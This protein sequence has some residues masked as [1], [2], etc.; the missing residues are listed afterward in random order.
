MKMKKA[1]SLLAA[2][3][4][5][6]VVSG[7]TA[8]ADPISGNN[9]GSGDNDTEWNEDWNTAS[10]KCGDTMEWTLDTSDGL[11]TISGS[12]NMW[13]RSSHGNELW[14]SSG[15][16]STAFSENIRSIGCGS[17]SGC[18]ELTSVTLPRSIK[19]IGESAFEGCTS[20]TD[21]Q[22]FNTVEVIGDNCFSGCDSLTDVYFKGSRQ[23]WLFLTEGVN[24][25]ISS[26]VSMHYTSSISITSQP[27]NVKVVPGAVVDFS[28]KATGNGTLKYQWYFRK[29]GTSKWSLWKKHTTETVSAASNDTWDG[30]QV[31]CRIED[32]EN[33][34]SS[35]V[36]IITLVDGV[37]IITQPSNVTVYSGEEASF[38]V[39]AQGNALNYQWYYRKSGASTWSVWKSHTTSTTTARAN[40]T[41]DGMQVYCRVSNSEGA[42]SDSKPATI[43][44]GTMPRILTHPSDVTVD[45]GK[46]VSFTVKAEGSGLKYQWYFKKSGASSWNIWKSHTTATTTARANDTWNGMQVYCKVSDS[47]GAFSDSQ[48]AT[49]RL[50][51][52]PVI[53]TQPADVTVDSGKE[54]SFTVKAEG[55]NLQY[56]WYFKKSGASG[57]SVWKSHTS[58]TTT[59][60]ANDTWDG[61]QVYCVVTD[62]IG[63]TV[64]S[65]SA[66]VK[67]NQ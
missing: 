56:Q 55:S 24:T 8:Y 67:L 38:T 62:G 60:R 3:L 22:L 23:D 14:I 31:Y 36:C 37:K 11:L 39:K 16:K 54:V 53:M 13:D 50:G 33:Y 9:Y 48:S 6:F 49:I 25:G 10:G 5:T 4:L 26:S 15:I 17:F 51:G 65:G 47:T 21:I 63:R 34:I 44:L 7:F 20:L 1:L 43:R 66:T 58:A 19:T 61:M 64:S 45:S 59:A 2:F 12:G 29:N 52:M 41:W 57:W 35:N 32:S 27:E 18:T 40:D 30:M 42:F 28:V 46:E